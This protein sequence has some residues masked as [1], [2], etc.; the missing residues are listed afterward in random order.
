[1][2]SGVRPAPGRRDWP[3][4]GYEV[5]ALVVLLALGWV[6][7]VSIVQPESVLLTHSGV[8]SAAISTAFFLIALGA[9]YVALTEFL[10]YG[11]LS[12]LCI[13]LAFLA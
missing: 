8:L 4:G 7:I 13:A 11:W 9:C 3:L 2:A 1:M 12:S 5:P 10:L 6:T